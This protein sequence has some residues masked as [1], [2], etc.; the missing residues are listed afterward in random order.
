[1]DIVII[2]GYCLLI[3]LFGPFTLWWN[4][5]LLLG[6]AIGL[7]GIIGFMLYIVSLAVQFKFKLERK[8]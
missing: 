3:L 8:K 2:I 4:I 1:M 7:I 6:C 5:A